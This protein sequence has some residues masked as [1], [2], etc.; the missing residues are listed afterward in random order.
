V[1]LTIAISVLLGLGIIAWGVLTA[2]A[3][4][5]PMLVIAVLSVTFFSALP[6]VLGVRSRRLRN[7]AKRPGATVVKWPPGRSSES[8]HRQD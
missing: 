1:K 5:A 3:D 2:G 8:S 6:V 7:P 4:H